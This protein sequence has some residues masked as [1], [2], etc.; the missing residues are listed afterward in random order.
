MADRIDS[1]QTIAPARDILIAR[2][3]R[4]VSV[5]EKFC[6]SVTNVILNGRFTVVAGLD[7]IKTHDAM[8]SEKTI[9][10]I[11]WL[12]HIYSLQDTRP[13]QLADLEA[14][15]RKHDETYAANPWFRLWKRYGI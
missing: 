13:L 5:I 15:N 8:K 2:T 11:E 6:C 4:L 7:G 3:T 9:S 12:E 1:Y 10:E 14:A